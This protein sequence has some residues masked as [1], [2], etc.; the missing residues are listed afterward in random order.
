MIR[1]AL[2]R[3]AVLSLE[4][5]SRAEPLVYSIDSFLGA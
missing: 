2:M 4:R 5:E 1:F 3:F